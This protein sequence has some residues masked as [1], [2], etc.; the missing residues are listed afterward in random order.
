M[1]TPEQYLAQAKEAAAASNYA[2]AA[3]YAS[4]A[5]AEAAIATMQ[6]SV[7][8]A[9]YPG[10]HAPPLIEWCGKCHAPGRRVRLDGN[11]QQK[12][13]R[14]CSYEV[15]PEVRPCRYCQTYIQ[16]EGQSR[17]VRNSTWAD[18]SGSRWCPKAPDPSLPQTAT[19]EA[20]PTPDSLWLHF[21]TALYSTGEYSVGSLVDN[22]RKSYYFP[23]TRYDQVPDL[24]LLEQWLEAHL[25]RQHLDARENL[26][27]RLVKTT[28]EDG[29]ALWAADRVNA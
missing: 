26:I 29:E 17:S 6:A 11:R 23:V 25:D 21:L 10:E 4:I 14:T 9:L 8:P 28:G 22:Y 15:Q 24:E 16:T 13:C 7:P 12:P 19:V 18:S 3:A 5:A 1:T 27:Y 20:D 2:E